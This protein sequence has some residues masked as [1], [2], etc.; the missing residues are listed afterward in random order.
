VVARRLAR[1]GEFRGVAQVAEGD[2]FAAFEV[3][4]RL[5][6]G[7]GSAPCCGQKFAVRLGEADG[8]RCHSLGRHY[9]NSRSGRQVMADRNEPVE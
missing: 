6:S 7:S 9:G 8:A 1:P 3:D 5:S 4:R 2:E